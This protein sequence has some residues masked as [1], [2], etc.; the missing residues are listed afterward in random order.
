MK[1]RNLKNILALSIIGIITIFANFILTG[2][3]NDDI[4][5]QNFRVQDGWVQ[6][7]KDGENWLNLIEAGDSVNEYDFRI[8]DGYIQW[9]TDG[10]TW[11]NL[12]KSE[13]ETNTYTITYDYG[14]AKDMFGL[15][16]Q[17]S[18][19]RENTWVM[20]LPK[21]YLNSGFIGWF[22]RGTDKIISEYD[23]IS[24][25]V[26][27]EARFNFEQGPAGIYENGKYIKTWQEL[28]NNNDVIIEDDV[29]TFCRASGNLKI[30]NTITEIAANAFDNAGTDFLTGIAIPDSVTRI[31]KN[32]FY[33]LQNL[34]N[35]KIGSGVQTIDDSAF[36]HCDKLTSITIPQNVVMIGN[37][38]FY[39][40]VN[41]T[42]FILEENIETTWKI[43]SNANIISENT[44]TLT[45]KQLLS[46]LKKGYAFKQI[47]SRDGFDYVV[48]P[49]NSQHNSEAILTHIPNKNITEVQVV[50]KIGTT[51][52]T[53]IDNWAFAYC[54][55]LTSV[56]IPAGVKTIGHDAFYFCK[57]L[58][59][60]NI[61]D[62]VT[63]I[64][65]YAFYYCI[66]LK[67]ATLGKSVT[68]IGSHSF[69]ICSN[70]TSI[71]IPESVTTISN[72]AFSD[73]SKLTTIIFEN[74]D[75]YKWLVGTFEIETFT[76]SWKDA[77]ESELFNLA[78]NGFELKRVIK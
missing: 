47:T 44:S 64:G 73:C 25:N 41:L 60:I 66:S 70:L 18:T 10:K 59:N 6:Y 4:N 19:V 67:E 46:Y 28:I 1:I 48:I 35:V 11:E 3:N 56:T 31:G 72:N 8:H 23:Y 17:T 68:S 21:C 63:T 42:S 62:S 12:V 39:N 52:V 16:P 27:L 53:G 20:D 54:C 37:Y 58:S 50:D 13:N 71:T 49:A 33:S 65:D 5:P 2:C 43:Y 78:K 34:S 9:T 77:Q 57:S 15:A 55:D 32:A 26:T 45:D 22:I 74:K 69:N 75:G 29:L 7:T 40:C 76:W 36:W 38:A 51:P 14:A 61:P 30:D 24:G